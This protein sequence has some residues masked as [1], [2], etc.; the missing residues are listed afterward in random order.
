MT[1]SVRIC[2]LLRRA[3]LPLY[4]LCHKG[5]R[6][7]GLRL[8]KCYLT[9]HGV[10][11]GAGLKMYSL[12]LCRRHPDAT[13]KLGRHV[14]VLN[15][16]RENPAGVC[17]RTV[18]VANR[19]G[20][21]LVIGDHVG[22][23]GAVIFCSEEIVIEDYVGIGAGARIYD[24]DFHPVS[25]HVRREEKSGIIRCAP[26]HIREGAWIAANVTILKGVTIGARS[27]VATGAVVTR[28]IPADT[29]AAGIPAR[30]VRSLL[31]A[32]Q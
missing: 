32:E 13:V 5:W 2:N 23:S 26:V 9:W 4:R 1:V 15:T 28:D 30:V 21:R 31:P 12:P 27:V 18:L 17:H 20:A 19:P 14:A 6:I 24:T 16:L 11:F 22:I 29:L 8:A 7:L 3:G 10:E 25:A